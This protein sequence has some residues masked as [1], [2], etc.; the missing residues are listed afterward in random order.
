MCSALINCCEIASAFIE[1]TG[2]LARRESVLEETAP[3]D[4]M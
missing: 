1:N 3:A 4:T 2:F